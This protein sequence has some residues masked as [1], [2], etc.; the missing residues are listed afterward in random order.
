MSILP[1]VLILLLLILANGL[2]A[3]AEIAIVSARKAR[4]QQ[5]AEEGDAGARKA[6]ELANEPTR[7]LS[8]VQIG[9]TLIGTLAGAFGG[10]TLAAEIARPLRTV[11]GLAA[12]ADAISLFVVVVGIAYLS[13]VLGELA[14][15][16]LGLGHAERIAALLAR[17]MAALARLAA[18]LVSLLSLSTGFVLRI[19]RVHPSEE[20]PVTEEEVRILIDTGREAG[21]FEPSEQELVENVFRLGDRRVSAL[22]TPHT[23]LV[24]LDADAPAQANWEKIAASPYV[25]FPVYRDHPDNVLGLVSVKALW[26]ELIAGR[27]PVLTEH[28]EQPLFVPES[29]PALHVLGRLRRTGVQ[30]ALVLDEYGAIMGLVTLFDLLEGLVGE[31]ADIGEE[32]PDIAQ[33]S[34]GSWLVDGLLPID[35]FEDYF[36]VPIQPDEEKDYQ[37][38]G[39]FVMMQL[40]HVPVVGD[41]FEWRGLAFEVV[42]MDQLRVDKLLVSRVAASPA[43]AGA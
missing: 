38:V 4:L 33:R 27:Q 17:P 34:D 20:P 22:A 24:R 11:P 32:T 8:T 12:S 5:R 10:A 42:D 16:R 18:P 39:G 2:F 31:I 21:V 40:G 36:D 6:L 23:E 25:H 35:A 15:K 13:L 1:E 41:R 14:P 9:I 28:L 19:L 26:N 7:F 43:E 37:T 30:V 29:T 3:M